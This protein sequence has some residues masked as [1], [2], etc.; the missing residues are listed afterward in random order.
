MIDK[1]Q[2]IKSKLELERQHLINLLPDELQQPFKDESY[3]AGGAIYSLYNTNTYKDIDLFIRTEELKQ[4]LFTYFKSLRGLQV[5]FYG[6]ETM[7]YGKY[8]GL[9]LVITNNAITIGDH[10]IILKDYGSPEKVVG[11]FDFK[12]NMFYVEGDSLKTLSDWQALEMK[13]LIYNDERARDIVGTIMRV[14]K[15]LGRGMTINQ[16]EMSKML[17]KLHKEGF[18]EDELNVLKGKT[19]SQHFGSGD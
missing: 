2:Y 13:E 7:Y 19:S 3:I 16:K 6:S 1:K 10:Q 9:N 17:L 18:N 5:K 8:K 11:Q 15:F 12:H 14:P 4:K